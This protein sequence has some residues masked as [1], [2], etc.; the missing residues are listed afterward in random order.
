MSIRR[1]RRGG[2][3]IEVA[4]TMPVFLAAIF[5][6]MDYAWYFYNEAMSIEATRQG[7][8]VGAVVPNPNG[9]S[10]PYP[11]ETAAADFINGELQS[12]GI[13][14]SNVA[15]TYDGSW[16]SASATAEAINVAQVTSLLGFEML[17]CDT[18]LE[19]TPLVGLVPTPDYVLSSATFEVEQP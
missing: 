9:D 12:T 15:V 1:H 7:C 2:N 17:Q 18:Y 10:S 11:T 5:G 4:L 14:S 6:L 19:F 16:T 13:R 3:A 8:R